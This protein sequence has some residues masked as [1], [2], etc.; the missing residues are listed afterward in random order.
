MPGDDWPSLT[1]AEQRAVAAIRR[2][3]DLEY[4]GGDGGRSR[5]RW[6][7]IAAAGSLIV[8]IAAVGLAASSVI[9]SLLTLRESQS[10]TAVDRTVVTAD[11]TRPA[12]V[13]P[14]PDGAT[15]SVHEALDSWLAATRARDI[16]GQMAFYPDV[17][18]VFYTWR[19]AS[20]ASVRR[21]KE[22]V[23]GEARVLDIRAGAPRI[24]V[25][26]DGSAAVT[27]FRK[28]YV[29]EGPRVR[30]RGEVVQELRWRRTSRGWTIVSERDAA[31]L[32][33]D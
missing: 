2:Q 16:D 33:R 31:L 29:I 26:P 6:R 15:G 7:R 24:D 14:A 25:A 27:R 21:E 5:R 30:R 3:I 9:T 12:P 13:P 23:L 1:D 32:R 10:A 22:K 19:N 17:V 4:G 8:L 18:P 11:A 20:M 28:A